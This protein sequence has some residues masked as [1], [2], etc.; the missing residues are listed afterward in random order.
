VTVILIEHFLCERK[1]LKGNLVAEQNAHA[2]H[3]RG[4]V[5][6]IDIWKK[7]SQDWQTI[8]KNPCPV[9][10]GYEDSNLSYVHLKY[11]LF[12]NSM[13]LQPFVVYLTVPF[14]L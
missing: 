6:T 5:L 4:Q 3:K 14:E 9:F 12:H 13:F 1:T 7:S 2:A 11:F 8:E 10:R